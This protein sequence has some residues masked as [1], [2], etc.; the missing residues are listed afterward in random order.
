[1]AEAI[2]G[3]SFGHQVSRDGR[4]EI[5]R[6][7]L[8]VALS[9]LDEVRANEGVVSCRAAIES[10]SGESEDVRLFEDLNNK[11]ESKAEVILK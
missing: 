8:E 7:V 1:M 5:S 6:V 3:P 4:V 9:V 2:I 10:G 11:N